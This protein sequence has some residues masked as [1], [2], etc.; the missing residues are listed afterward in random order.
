MIIDGKAIAESIYES[1]GSQAS[2]LKLGIVVASHDPVI[3]SFVRIKTKAAQRLGIEMRRA[4]LLNQPT[5]ADA[6]A[7]IEK[8]APHVN[9]LIVQLPLPAELDTDAVLKAI[10][11]YLDV[12]ALNP[13]V[14]EGDRIVQAPVAE[15]IEEI[16]KRSNVAIENKK[17]VV[18]GGGR[19]VGAPA[20]AMLQRLG[21]NVSIITLEEGSL[22]EL[23]NADIVVSGA[24]SPGLIKPEMI[25]EG[26]VLIDAGTSESGGKIIG[27]SDPACAEKC[28]VF[29]PVPGGVGPV[30]VAMI[31]RNLRS[32]SVHD[33]S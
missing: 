7:A 1:L 22:N 5:T 14:K 28:A 33:A 30:A 13:A 20:A 29:T 17:C 6:I 16:L 32:L 23:R 15:A 18:V 9:G 26:A 25:K 10:P 8:L 4:D 27:D 19:L 11:P 24:G 21:G 2:G 31:F 12:D 3:E